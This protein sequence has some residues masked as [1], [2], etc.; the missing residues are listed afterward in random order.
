MNVDVA[1][2]LEVDRDAPAIARQLGIQVSAASGL[3]LEWSPRTVEPAQLGLGIRHREIREATVRRYGER[4][5]VVAGGAIGHFER[6]ADQLETIGVETLCDECAAASE[7]NMSRRRV[8]RWCTDA[9][10]RLSLH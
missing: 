4:R 1:L 2:S 6:F 8:A 5:R 9:P 7:Q 10:K 3:Q